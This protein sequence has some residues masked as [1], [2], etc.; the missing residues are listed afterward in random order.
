[1]APFLRKDIAVCRAVAEESGADLGCLRDVAE[2]GPLHL[3]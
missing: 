2:G 1:V 3:R